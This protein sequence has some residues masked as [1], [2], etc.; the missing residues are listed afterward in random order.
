M[1]YGGNDDTLMDLLSSP[2]SRT[3]SKGDSFGRYYEGQTPS[4]RIENLVMDLN[5]VLVAAPDFDLLMI[6]LGKRWALL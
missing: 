4:D 6:L 5:G 2:C 3:T 1:G